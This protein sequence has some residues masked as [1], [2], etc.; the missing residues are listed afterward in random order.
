[1]YCR[2]REGLQREE[3]KYFIYCDYNNFN[4]INLRMNLRN[5]LE[6]CPTY[7][8]NFEYTIANVLDAHVPK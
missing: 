1:M 5:K 8:E 2:K 3:P 6:E 4:D 7:Y